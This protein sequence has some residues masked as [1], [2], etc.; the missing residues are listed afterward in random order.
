MTRIGCNP[1]SSHTDLHRLTQ[2]GPG[3][4]VGPFVK[5]HPTDFG[6]DHIAM[7]PSLSMFQTSFKT[8]VYFQKVYV[9]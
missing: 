6:V 5:I 4:C 7:R 8:T 2:A 9:V 1:V 3:I